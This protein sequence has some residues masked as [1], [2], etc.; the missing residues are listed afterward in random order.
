MAGNPKIHRNIYL[1]GIVSFIN[2]TA[3][4]M[5]LPILPL[6]IQ[7]MGGGG[8]AFGLVDG[9]GEA[10]AAIFKIFSGNL[11]DRLGKRKPFVFFGYLFA[12]ISKLLL[13]FASSWPLVLVLRSCERLGK[14]ARESPRDALIAESTSIENRG[15]GFGIHRAFDS[16]GAV[17]GSAL[18]LVLY[19]LF[20]FS[21]AAIFLVAGIISFVSIAPLFAVREKKAKVKTASLKIGFSA[22]PKNLQAFILVATIFAFANFS[23][24]FFVMGSSMPLPAGLAV[25]VPIALYA[26]YNLVSAVFAVPAGILS[27]KIGRKKVLI[28][29]YSLFSL[30]CAGFI[31]LDSPWAFAV[32]FFVYG[33]FFAF[34]DATEK[35]LVS[36]LARP[37]LKGTALGTFQAFTGI[38]SLPAGI[39]AG[40]LWDSFGH[41]SV[42]AYGAAVSFFAVALLAAFSA[43]RLL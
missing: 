8:L 3:S 17:L 2:D 33:L 7:S 4:K 16:G 9:I 40:L 32:L 20:G 19:W 34:V 11:S 14:G 36:D 22:L 24:M 37:E 39:I 21:F 23:Y 12:S 25:V 27:D 13:A 10:V 1:L 38:A 5:I 6:F 42:F 30:T 29:G 43:K 18:A 35:A 15:A 41:V 28:A 26:L 31:F